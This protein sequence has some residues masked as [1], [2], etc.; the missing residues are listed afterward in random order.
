MSRR[1]AEERAAATAGGQGRRDE[2]GWGWAS[3]RRLPAIS[4]TRSSRRPAPQQRECERWRLGSRLI[5]LAL[6]LGVSCHGS[7]QTPAPARGEAAPDPEAAAGRVRVFLIAPQD[8]GRGGRKV[9]CDDS[10]VPVEVTVPRVGPALESA[11]RALL[12][13]GDRYDR[14]SGLLNPLYAS[15]LELAGVERRGVQATVRLSGYVELG[16]PCDNA[17]ILAELTETA[18]QFRGISFVQ[19]EVDGRP[20]RTLLQGGAASGPAAPPA[21]VAPASP[22]AAPATAA[23]PAG[24]EPGAPPGAPDPGAPPGELGPGAPPGA[25]GPAASSS[26]AEPAAPPA[27]PSGWDGR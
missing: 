17:R 11:L 21:A 10:A 19:F 8:R 12:A 7:A 16:D 13:M 27:A 15:R 3:D 23:P 20:L 25:P 18:L 5:G 6:L 1:R 9:A 14:A 24:L 22:S 26:V 2:R 4:H